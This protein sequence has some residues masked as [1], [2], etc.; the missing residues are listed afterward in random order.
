MLLSIIPLLIHH[1]TQRAA[2]ILFDSKVTQR[3]SWPWVGIAI[4]ASVLSE[5]KI[6]VVA[7][8][9]TAV[10]GMWLHRLGHFR[11]MLG[12]SATAIVQVSGAIATVLFAFV[13]QFM[14]PGSAIVS[15]SLWMGLLYLLPLPYLDGLRIFFSNPATYISIVAG[16]LA[17]GGV[18]LLTGN[19]GITALC[20]AVLVGIAVAYLWVAR[21]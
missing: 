5:Q 12:T 13:A 18:Y 16:V 19:L 3:I 4:I 9:Q 2:A 14:A 21:L 20:L 7:L 10:E 11:Y 6:A 15:I 17:T 1:V 8:T